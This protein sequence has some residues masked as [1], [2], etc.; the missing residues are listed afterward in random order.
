MGMPARRKLE[1]T[2]RFSRGLGNWRKNEL[3]DM[4][5]EVGR[6]SKFRGGGQVNHF[7]GLVLV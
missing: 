4:Q 7:G 6:N 2:Q 1:S 5:R 3:K